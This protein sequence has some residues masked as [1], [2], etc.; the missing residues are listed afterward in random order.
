MKFNY[1]AIV[2]V[3]NPDLKTHGK[4]G[5]VTDAYFDSSYIKF[6]D[7]T[8]R[9]YNNKNLTLSTKDKKEND[10]MAITGNFKVAKIK[11]LGG[12][13]TTS[14]FEYAMFDDYNVEDTVV[15]SSANH[16]LGIAKIHE[17]I[18]KDDATTKKFEREVVAKVDLNPWNIRVQNRK[19]M[20]ELNSK[21]EKRAAELNKL[22]V[23][24]MLAEKDPSLQEMLNEYKELIGG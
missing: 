14:L 2:R 16:G 10:N 6:D 8:T 1:G 23:F 5:T 24:E 22:A 17:I 3:C 13:N 19:K 12:S 4:I 20:H 11:F 21:M 18:D 7:G 9:Y 15:V